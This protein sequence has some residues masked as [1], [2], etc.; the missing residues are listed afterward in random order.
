MTVSTVADTTLK[1]LV[2]SAEVRSRISYK[3]KEPSFYKDTLHLYK[4]SNYH[5]SI[6]EAVK[7]AHEH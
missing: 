5:A 4:V 2:N 3:M 7:V 6:N 1:Y